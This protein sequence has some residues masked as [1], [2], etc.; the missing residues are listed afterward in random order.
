MQN[1]IDKMQSFIDWM[2]FTEAEA[3]KQ[4]EIY[5]NNKL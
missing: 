1:R 2:D 3:K 5:I 4:K